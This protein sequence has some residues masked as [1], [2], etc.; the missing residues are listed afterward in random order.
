MKQKL[1]CQK[2]LVTRNLLLVAL[3]LPMQ[4]VVVD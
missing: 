2:I 1:I 3:Q 4:Q